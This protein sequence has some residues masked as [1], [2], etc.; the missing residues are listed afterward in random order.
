MINFKKPQYHFFYRE[1]IPRV[2][3]QGFHLNSFDKENTRI[4]GVGSLRINKKEC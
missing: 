3:G 1:R 4:S 2:S